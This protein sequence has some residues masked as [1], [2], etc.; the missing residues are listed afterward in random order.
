[1]TAPTLPRV[2]AQPGPPAAERAP[3]ATWH[4]VTAAQT[5]DR[6]AFAELFRR[7]R[8]LVFNVIYRRVNNRELAE[9]L[10]QDVF[11]RALKSIE[12]VTWQGR[13]IGAWLVT[14]ARNIVID[15]FKSG[16]SRLEY[17]VGDVM[18]HHLG[19]DF[20]DHSPEGNPA[21]S[22][23]AHL[24][25]VELLTAVKTL[26]GDQQDVVILRFLHGLSVAETAA[27]VGKQEGAVKAI[28]YRACRTLARLLPPSIRE[29][30]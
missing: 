10:T 3:E 20:T 24:V 21:A 17:T 27:A 29:T 30:A 1:M 19:V 7:Y 13:D 28:Q 18:A 12:R 11:L 4:L 26:T 6:D 2:P 23:V 15:H 9:D 5:G 14:I 8:P 25:N 16:R 22:A